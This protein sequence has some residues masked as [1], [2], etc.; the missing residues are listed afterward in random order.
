MSLNRVMNEVKFVF[1]HSPHFGSNFNP[2][3]LTIWP[4]LSAVVRRWQQ[5]GMPV[6]GEFLRF[7][8][9]ASGDVL[10]IMSQTFLLNS[11]GPFLRV[12][13]RILTFTA[14]HAACG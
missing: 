11:F 14:F 2:P 8:C 3:D 6:R 10:Q 4:R 13:S 5:V 1:Q 9:R 7:P 12:R